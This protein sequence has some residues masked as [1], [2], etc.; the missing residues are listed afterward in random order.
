MPTDLIWHSNG[1]ELHAGGCERSTQGYN[2][3]SDAEGLIQFL[4]A[5]AVPLA[6]VV[7]V[8]GSSRFRSGEG[9][10]GVP[11]G[12]LAAAACMFVLWLTAFWI[13]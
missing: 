3:F 2:G 9:D 4:L 12:A 7:G 8:P 1:H 6:G 5:G 10:L 13:A 11:L